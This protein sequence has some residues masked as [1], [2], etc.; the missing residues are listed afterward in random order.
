MEKMKASSTTPPR[1]NKLQSVKLNGLPIKE[2]TR[3]S[4][5]C[6]VFNHQPALKSFIM[7][8]HKLLK[9]YLTIPVT[10]ANAK[11]NLSALKL[12]KT[13]IRHNMVYKRS[14]LLLTSGSSWDSPA[15]P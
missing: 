14:H 12:V 2:V 10:T 15:Q 6:D 3:I 8:M 5:I 11:R 4:T 13:N 7:E 9:L 1:C